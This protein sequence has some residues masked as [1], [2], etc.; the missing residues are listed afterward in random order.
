MRKLILAVAV[1]AITSAF[2][3]RLIG[4][5]RA[6]IAKAQAEAAALGV[7]RD[8]LIA[9]VQE[10][11][12]LIVS[13][14]LHGDSLESLAQWWRDSVDMLE[15]HRAAQELAIRQT[16]T[17]TTLEAELR[18]AFPELGPPC[19]PYPPCSAWRVATVPVAGDTVGIEYLMVPAWFAETF[20]IDHDN[21]ESWRAQ[22]DRLLAADSLQLL[23]TT[24]Q[25][26]ITRL[27]QA[28][29]EA[30][31]SGYQVAYAN[32]QQLS[33]QYV[34]ELKKPRITLGSTARI[35]FIAGAGLVIGREIR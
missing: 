1:L 29:A 20:V 11:G 6:A 15:Q 33:K 18:A 32:Y 21:A 16:G 5:N 28:R 34:A 13:F 14:G 19:P 22:K 9:V 25:D 3:T 8:S 7:E 2:V 31:Q 27:E 35:L 26:S 10:R 23:V 30:Y 12:K 24:L 17:L 4:S